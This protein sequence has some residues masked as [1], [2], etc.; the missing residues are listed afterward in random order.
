MTHDQLIK[1]FSQSTVGVA[2]AAT[3]VT[4]AAEK[5]LSIYVSSVDVTVTTD[6][7][8]NDVIISVK[9]GSTIV[10]QATLPTDTVK[11]TRFRTEFACPIKASFPNNAVLT[12]DAPNGN[13]LI[14][15]TIAGW[16]E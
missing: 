8:A 15:A 13:C 3:T 6:S 4:V 5:P 9:N 10:W 2:T 1:A 16:K 7:L 12:V 11:G 14:Q